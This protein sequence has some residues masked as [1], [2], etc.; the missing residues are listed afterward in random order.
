MM[1]TTIIQTQSRIRIHA[2]IAVVT[3]KTQPSS[4][5]IREADQMTTTK[6]SP[7]ISLTSDLTPNRN[8][9][10]KMK[11][12]VAGARVVQKV[13]EVL[14]DVVGLE[15][16]TNQKT[17]ADTLTDIPRIEAPTTGERT[18]TRANP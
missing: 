14:T 7:V 11:T 3:N 15:A 8:S 1:E 17:E 13:E 10:M 9:L 18:K 16:E 6:M 4:V 5:Q 12:T 2:E